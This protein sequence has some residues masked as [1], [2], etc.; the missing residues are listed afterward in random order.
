MTA[1]AQFQIAIRSGVHANASDCVSAI[2]SSQFCFCQI[3]KEQNNFSWVREGEVFVWGGTAPLPFLPQLRPS[4]LSLQ[5][6]TNSL[7][8]VSATSQCV[9]LALQND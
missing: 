1:C 9:Y 4:C 2:T 8:A 5:P 7:N 3:R 6:T